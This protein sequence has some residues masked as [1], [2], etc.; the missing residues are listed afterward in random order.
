[1]FLSSSTQSAQPLQVIE[2]PEDEVRAHAIHL[3]TTRTD[4]GFHESSAKTKIIHMELSLRL[5]FQLSRSLGVYTVGTNVE[6]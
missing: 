2:T 6:F 3:L 5:S 4:L 1:M